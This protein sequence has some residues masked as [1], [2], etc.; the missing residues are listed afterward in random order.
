MALILRA[1]VMPPTR[2]VS[3]WMTSTARRSSRSLKPYE[4]NSC[5]PPEIG[6]IPI[7]FSSM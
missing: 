2:L 6:M 7:F 3:Y 4:V 1:A 5:S